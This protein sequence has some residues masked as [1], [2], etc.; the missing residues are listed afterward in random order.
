[1]KSLISEPYDKKIPN[2]FP[3]KLLAKFVKL[4]FMLYLLMTCITAYPSNLSQSIKYPCGNAF[5]SF[6][7]NIF[8]IFVSYLKARSGAQST[9]IAVCF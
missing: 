9:K 6:L 5:C 3:V 7:L 1:M 2:H 4:G 8:F